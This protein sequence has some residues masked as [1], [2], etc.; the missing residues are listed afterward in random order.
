MLTSLFMLI[1]CCLLTSYGALI[2]IYR[3]AWN[4]IPA[5]EPDAAVHAQ[6]QISVLIPARNEEAN[7]AQ[8][9]KSLERQSYPKT[10]YQVIVID[11]HSTDSTREM[12]ASVRPP[13]L[14]LI[15]ARL[16]DDANPGK[17]S[18]ITTGIAISS[19]DLI[20]TTDADC[21]F[22][23][24]WL[25]TLAAFHGQKA[26]KFIAAPVR[27]GEAV[28]GS[29]A[30][31]AK[32]AV[33]FLSI[34]QILDFISLQG[35]TGAAVNKNIHSMCNGANLAYEKN[36]FYEVGGFTGVDAIPTGDDMLLM[37]K[38]YTRYPDKVFFLKSPSA[39]VSTKPET[40]WAALF[41]QR[42]RWASKA[43][44]Y[45]DKRIFWVLLLVYLLNAMFL[46]LAVAAC[47]QRVWLWLL[48]IGLIAKTLFELPFVNTVAGF[49]GQRPLV[50]WFPLLQ[51]LH[52]FYTV[53]VGWMGKFGGY[54][55][56]DR[57]IVK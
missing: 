13:E 22:H 1:C 6:T 29:P 10:L 17:K 16:A 9:I 43:D 42:V 56:K 23:P 2:E 7:I 12:V 15:Y 54:R 21:R 26:A 8:C 45:D 51:P 18:A 32:A 37:H 44:R 14:N 5:F 41:H 33:S 57:T 48:L 19:G 47:W 27:M 39:I 3:K 31:T 35:I 49:F 50:R 38:I 20:V 24:N 53:V 4:G 25:T 46:L 30:R 52:I 40:S 28:N 36:A 11:D 34:F 55:W